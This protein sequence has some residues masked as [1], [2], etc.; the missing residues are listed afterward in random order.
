MRALGGSLLAAALCAGTVGTASADQALP[1]PI[2]P[3]APSAE[4]PSIEE[5]LA[6]LG[7]DVLAG[8]W[9]VEVEGSAKIQGGNAAKAKQAQDKVV[10]AAKAEGIAV[11][12]GKSYTNTWNGVAV[13][14][15]KADAVKLA[16]IAGVKGVYPV[17]EVTKPAEDAARPDIDYARTLTGADV[18]NEELG[19][20]GKDIKVGIIDSGIDYNHPDFGGSGVNAETRDFPGERVK[21]GHDY[22]G[23]VY[24]ASSD[25]PAINTPKPDQWP[26]DCGGHGTHVAGIVGADGGVTGVA[27]DVEF[28]AYRV[29]GCDGSSDSEIIIAA[30]DQAYADGMDIVNMS[31]GASLQTWPTYPT[32]T[33]ADRLVDAGVVVVVSQGN[34][35]TSGTFSGGAPS[36]AHNVISVGSVDNSEYMADYISTAGGVETPFMTSTGSPEPT[37]GA[38]YTLVAGDPLNACAPLA[39]ATGEGQAVIVDRGTCSFHLKALAAQVAGYDAVIVANNAPGVINMTVEGADEITIPAV[40]VLQAD[41]AALKAEIAANGGSTT[42]DFSEEPKRFDN[43]TGGYQSDFSSYGLAADLTLKPDVSAPGG[44]IYSTYPLEKK[45]YA[46]LGGTSMAAPHV[47]GAAA[48]LLEARPDLDPYEVRTILANTANPFT[49]GTLP[50]AGVAEPVHRQGAGLIDIPHALTTTTTVTPH[51]ISLGEGEAGPVTTT[52]TVHNA[53]DVEVTYALDVEHGVATYGPTDVPGFYVLDATV[54]FSADSI[55]VPAGGTATATVVISEDFTDTDDN[56]VEFKVH[57]AIYGGWIT[58]TSETEQLVVPFAGLSGDYQALQAVE[59]AALTYRNANGG[60]SVA[61]PWRTFTMVDGDIP[62]IA[63][64]LGVPVS[65]LY[66]DVY[67]AN[68]DGTKGAK[69]H[70]NFINYATEFD[71]GRMGAVATIAWDGTYQGNSGNS[72]LRRVAEGSYV[73]EL[74]VLK[75]LGDPT[76][77]DHWE[78]YDLAP[79]TIDYA[80]GADTSA[81]NGPGAGNPN[82]G[83]DNNS[84][85]GK[86]KGKP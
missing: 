53:S 46:T 16:G 44:S 72:K 26:D 9:L 76:N 80:D 32:A 22:V 23:D 79:L 71:L 6:T 49:W 50:E 21:W 47:A 57:G 18:A 83:K 51:K 84:G 25:D 39:E 69:V 4:A 35:G 74:R 36:V 27:P 45:G 66:V 70:S 75:A 13:S 24:D 78:T 43:P 34:S 14:A 63:L 3:A 65:G 1:E 31:L 82:K 48:L 40:S 67:K 7:D 60:L 10:A 37:P 61:A 33:A 54:E 68:P 52:L 59:L 55:T 38:S 29:F 28:G 42:I 81:G 5:M 30:M 2:G 12:V 64:Y 73:L 58:L 15:S 19:F 56:G 86:G 62:L 41:G 85:K 11:T 17:V 77:P 20:T 8:R